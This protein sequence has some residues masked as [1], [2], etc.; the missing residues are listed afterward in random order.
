MLLF[1]EDSP[2]LLFELEI[3]ILTASL[4]KNQNTVYAI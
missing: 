4:L 3:S 1:L 2:C